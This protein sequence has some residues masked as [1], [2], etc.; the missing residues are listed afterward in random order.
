MSHYMRVEYYIF[1]TIVQIISSFSPLEFR[2]E[3]NN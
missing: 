3:D 2:F 1:S